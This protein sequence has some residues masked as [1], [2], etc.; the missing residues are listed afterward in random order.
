MTTILRDTMTD[1]EILLDIATFYADECNWKP[2]DKFYT[3]ETCTEISPVC[4]RD[5]GRFARR[6]LEIIANRRRAA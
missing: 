1:D 5:Q 4:G 3:P 2:Y 6:G